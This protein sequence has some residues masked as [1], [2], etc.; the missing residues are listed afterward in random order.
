MCDYQEY[1]ESDLGFGDLQITTRSK[2]E[3]KL[4]FCLQLFSGQAEVANSHR[5]D[6]HATSLIKS[7]QFGTF[8]IIQTIIICFITDGVINHVQ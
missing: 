8:L 2:E 6:G 7:A 1:P 3:V 4:S 5:P